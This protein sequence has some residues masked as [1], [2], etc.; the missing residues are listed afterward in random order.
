MTL[1]DKLGEIAK[2][3]GEKASDLAKSAT[4]KAGELAEIAKINSQIS[5]QRKKITEI[6]SEMADYYWRKF[7]SGEELADEQTVNL[8]K[9]I[10]LCESE[11]T[12]LEAK[13]PS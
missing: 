7:Q 8:C 13:K 9:L 12:E 6:K 1:M 4:E 2:S 3:A 11:I 5:A 10:E